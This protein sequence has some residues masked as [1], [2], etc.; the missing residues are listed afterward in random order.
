MRR[1]AV[2]AGRPGRG[3]LLFVTGLLLLWSCSD[4]LN[5]PAPLGDLRPLSLR[6]DRAPA[7]GGPN[8]SIAE[9]LERADAARVRVQRGQASEGETVLVLDTV[10]AFARGEAAREPGCH[11][12][13]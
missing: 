7:P 3:W 8:P 4:I 9:A 2:S 10:V 1:I 11:R 13:R 12:G 5:D 6:L